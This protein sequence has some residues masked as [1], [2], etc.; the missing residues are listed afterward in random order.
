MENWQL[1]V[2]IL[3]SV[4]VGGL[5]PVIIMVALAHY[6]AAREIAETGAH[7]RRSLAKLD[8]IS[9]RAE[10]LSRGFKGGEEKIADLLTS[11]GH[12]ADG[13]ERNMNAINAVST[14]VG[15]LGTAVAAYFNSRS[16]AGDGEPPRGAE[17]VESGHIHN[18]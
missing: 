7:L 10:V 5:I 16:Q 9:D 15:S 6:R 1:A 13:I 3:A 4:I 8:V 2:V 14:I 12:L 18:Q 17:S 11:V